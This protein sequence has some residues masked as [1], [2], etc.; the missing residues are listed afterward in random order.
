MHKTSFPP[1]PLQTVAYRWI[2]F[3]D[4]FQVRKCLL[5]PKARFH[6]PVNGGKVPNVKSRP[7]FWKKQTLDTKIRK[8]AH[9]PSANLKAFLQLDLEIHEKFQRALHLSSSN[10]AQHPLISKYFQDFEETWSKL[11]LET[12]GSTRAETVRKLSRDP[13]GVYRAFWRFENYVKKLLQLAFRDVIGSVYNI[14]HDEGPLKR[15]LEDSMSGILVIQFAYDLKA[16]DVRH[17]CEFCF[18]TH[19]STLVNQT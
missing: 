8:F 6:F 5:E 1:S 4:Q 7:E 19:N 11:L 2:R 17:P 16:Q 3:N 9:S 14:S 13:L 10:K 12:N 15:D 18:Q